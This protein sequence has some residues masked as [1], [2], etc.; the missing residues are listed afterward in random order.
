MTKKWSCLVVLLILIVLFSGCVGKDENKVLSEKVVSE[1]N[2]GGKYNAKLVTLEI[3]IQNESYKA[4]NRKW[5]GKDIVEA[6][7][8]QY[9]IGDKHFRGGYWPEFWPPYAYSVDWIKINTPENT[10]FLNWWDY[11]HYIR[12]ATGRD[13]VIA[14]PS[15]EL[16]LKTIRMIGTVVDEKTYEERYGY[17]TPEKLK[18]VAIALTTDDITVTNQIMDK[19]NAKYI[20]TTMMDLDITSAMRIGL[21][22]EGYYTEVDTQQ[23]K[24]IVPS[25]KFYNSTLA[26]LHLFKGKGLENYRLVYESQPKSEGSKEKW[27]KNIYNVLYGGNLQ[28]EDSGYIKIFEYVKDGK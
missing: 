20:Y 14:Q 4:E 19:Y 27:N 10:T 24:Q 17:E 21:P 25:S 3:P 26:R 1:E 23:G 18:D 15:K 16:A 13:V 9:S 28:V 6:K 7:E 8:I 5:S 2:I 22:E 11:G 12:G